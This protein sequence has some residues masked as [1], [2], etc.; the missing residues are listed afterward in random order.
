MEEIN[1]FF[2]HLTNLYIYERKAAM[3]GASFLVVCEMKQKKRYR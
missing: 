3:K 2:I 1:S